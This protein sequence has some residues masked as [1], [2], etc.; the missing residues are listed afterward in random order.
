MSL[1]SAHMNPYQVN[2]TMDNASFPLMSSVVSSTVPSVFR[3]RRKLSGFCGEYLNS[4]RIDEDHGVLGNECFLNGLSF[5]PNIVFVLIAVPVLISWNKSIFAS[6][7]V[8]TWVRFPHH[9]FRWIM[10]F[11][12]ILLNTLEFVAGFLSDQ[13]LN[14]THLHLY[15]PHMASVA[16]TLVAVVYYHSVEMWNSPRFLL[17][18]IPYWLA[19]TVIEIMKTI[20]LNLMK[21]QLIFMRPHFTR[22]S[23]LVYI[24]LLLIELDVLRQLVID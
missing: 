4:T 5:V 6:M 9:T 12:L 1:N 15:I 23:I 24:L 10:F 16:G 22:V 3:A 7:H 19:L 8:K 14:G 20:N 17:L 13:L 11:A 21:I 18:L 2:A